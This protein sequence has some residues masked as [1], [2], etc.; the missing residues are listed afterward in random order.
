MKYKIMLIFLFFCHSTCFAAALSFTGTYQCKG[1]DPYLNKYYTGTVKIIPQ[2][3]V[4]RLTMEYD[5]GEKVVGTG[6]L[7][8]D[9]TISVVFQNP[10]DLKKV[11]LE[12]YSF[13]NSLK[14]IRGYWVYLGKDKLGKEVCTKM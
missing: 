11:G 12:L 5:T 6:G 9:D 8:D 10:K 2:N 14:E 1:F 7:S 3:T 4:Y 13:S